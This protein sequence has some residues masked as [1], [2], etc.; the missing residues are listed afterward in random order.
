MQ[1]KTQ[2]NKRDKVIGF[3]LDSVLLNFHKAFIK[4]HNRVYGDIFKIN[5]P[6]S[7]E[8]VAILWGGD[9][10]KTENEVID[11]YQSKEHSEAL[12]VESSFQAIK[13]LSKNNS[14]FVIT[15]RPDISK[16]KTLEWIN[17]NFPNMFEGVY[18]T[19]QFYGGGRVSSKEEFCKTL[20]IDIFVEDSLSNAKS[21]S[22]SGI[23]VLLLDTK[24]NQN[25]NITLVTRVYSWEE[26][27]KKLINK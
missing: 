22:N 11:F 12:R 25:K 26:I 4:Y 5:K 18:F 16:E 10:K 21:I 15:V 14:L 20:G 24:W 2:N 3:D 27:L 17:K 19:N 1:E 13:T 23:P 6:L 7:F 8:E 9:L